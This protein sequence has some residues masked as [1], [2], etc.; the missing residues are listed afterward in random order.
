DEDTTHRAR[1]YPKRY[2]GRCD[3][4]GHTFWDCPRSTAKK[5]DVVMA[6]GTTDD[7]D[8][9]SVCSVA[10]GEAFNGDTSLDTTIN[11][12][13]GEYA[14]SVDRGG[15][16]SQQGEGEPWMFD[17]GATQHFYHDSHGMAEYRECKGRVLRCAGGST[18]PIV[19]R[20]NLSLAFRSDGQDVILKVVDV[21][22]VPGVRHHLL[23]PTRV[24]H[25]GYTY[26]GCRTGFRVDL[27]SGNT[28]NIPGQP[29]QL[30]MYARRLDQSCSDIPQT[31]DINELHCSHAHVHE[32]LRRKTAK[33]QGNQLAGELQPCRGC[34]EAK[35]LRAPIPRST[36]TRAAKSAPR[37]FVDLSGPKPVKSYGGKS[38]TMMVRHDHSRHTKLYFLRK[39]DEAKIY[40]AKYIAWVS[41]RKIDIVRSDDGGEFLEGAFGELC[42]RKNI[43]QEK[44][45]ADSPQ[46]NGVAERAL[47]IIETAGLAAR[48]QASEL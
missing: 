39:K 11:G 20:G 40:F 45:T 4:Q 26:T 38:Y 42:D 48:I 14:L 35:G 30:R 24:Q 23:S 5:E 21:D 25:M 29:R 15:G 6:M 33:Q 41:P 2:C 44:T 32:D 37:V 3:Q 28:L 19:G 46:F 16:D 22:Q 10:D 47:G 27:N 17:T 36:H 12:D 13:T 43:K 18:Y 31:A 34:S 7:S 8:S 1:N 9:S